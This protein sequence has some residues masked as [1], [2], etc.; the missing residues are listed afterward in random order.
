[1]NKADV[2][3]EIRRVAQQMGGKSP[4][5]R[6]FESES[7]IKRDQVVGV[8]WA[9]WSDAIREAGFTPNERQVAY[10]ITYLLGVY[11][12]LARELSRLPTK[13]DVRLKH[14]R[15]PE[16]PSWETY[17]KRFT[18]KSGLVEHLA[19]YCTKRPGYEVVALLCRSRLAGEQAQEVEGSVDGAGDG[20]VYLAK[21]GRFY[22]IGRTQHIGRREYELAVQLPEKVR[23]VHVI[24]TDDPPGIESYWH[25]RFEAKR[26]NGE[27]F[28]LTPQDVSAFRRRKFM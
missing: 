12:D 25:R 4:G 24:K 26:K 17:R 22:K 2:L 6:T 1:M 10:E 27:W 9:R 15:D 28:E 13:D 20:F 14:R 18:G 16:F 3:S 7:G 19:A 11:A 21:S 5:L 23:T 8:F